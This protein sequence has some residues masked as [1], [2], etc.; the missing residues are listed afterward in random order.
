MRCLPDDVE[1]QEVSTDEFRVRIAEVIYG[2]GGDVLWPRA[3]ELADLVLW[4]LG[5]RYESVR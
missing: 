2:D 1:F 3:L 5:T 4:E